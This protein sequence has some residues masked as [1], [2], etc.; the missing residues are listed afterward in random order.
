MLIYDDKPDGESLAGDPMS[1]LHR[2]NHLRAEQGLKPVFPALVK[3]TFQ[4]V[5]R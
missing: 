5:K 3:F 2:A 4:R 1:Q